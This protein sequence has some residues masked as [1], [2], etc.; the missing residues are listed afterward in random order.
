[1]TEEL[2]YLSATNALAR[3]RAGELSPV[4][5]MEAVIERAQETEPTVNALPHTFYEEALV[6]ARE[7][8]RRYRDGTARALEGIPLALKEE[9]AVQGQPWTQGS[10]IHAET[11]A[12]YTSEF[13]RR[14]LDAGAIVLDGAGVLV[15]GLHPLP[16][17]RRHPQPAQP[18][19]GGRRLLRRLGRVAGSGL[20]DAGE[21]L[22]YRRLDP[23]AGGSVRRRRLQA[24]LWPRAVR[25]ALQPRH[26][27]PL[28]AAGAHGRRLRAV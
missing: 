8:E 26:L 5:L 23:D 11:I 18:R 28:R 27:L 2:C 13:A 24:A 12:D 3:F 20:D 7:A 16:H 9:E 22:G 4:E 17:P 6:A 21:R 19:A 25:P 1:M 10:L 15:R 14:H